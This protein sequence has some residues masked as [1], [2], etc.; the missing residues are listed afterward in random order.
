MCSLFFG[1][2]SN[3]LICLLLNLISMH[4]VHLRATCIAFLSLAQVQRDLTSACLL[5][6][7]ENCWE[8][9]K[10]TTKTKRTWF[11]GEKKVLLSRKGEKKNHDL[12]FPCLVTAL[13]ESWR[14]FC[15]TVSVL[16]WTV[17]V[18]E[19][20]HR[21]E[22]GNQITLFTCTQIPYTANRRKYFDSNHSVAKG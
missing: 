14:S 4:H 8:G 16:L 11:K 22:T 7:L 12:P 18:G 13:S 21:K 20:A 9:E 17:S 15:H 5:Y 2:P 19:K 6:K 3:N 1:N 10:K